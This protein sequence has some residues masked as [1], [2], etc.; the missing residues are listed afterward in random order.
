[1]ADILAALDTI[2]NASDASLQK[3]RDKLGQLLARTAFLLGRSEELGYKPGSDPICTPSQDSTLIPQVRLLAARDDQDARRL[4]VIDSMDELGYTDSD[5]TC[6]PPQNSIL[7]PRVRLLAAP[8]DQEARRLPG[9]EE[10]R[11]QHVTEL[12]DAIKTKL[13][14]IQK[15]YENGSSKFSYPV[16]MVEDSRVLDFTTCDGTKGKRSINMRI[17]RTLS[18]LSLTNDFVAWECLT[19]E[20]SK[21]TCHIN[22]LSEKTEWTG[23]INKFLNERR[24]IDK[25]SA[26]KMIS[27]GTK[28][29]V[30]QALS[31]IPGIAALLSTCPR[32]HEIPYTMLPTLIEG[33]LDRKMYDDAEAY[34]DWWES[35]QENYNNGSRQRKLIRKCHPSQYRTK[36]RRIERNESNI[37][38]RA[39]GHG[40]QN[41]IPEP[42]GSV[43]SEF[44]HTLSS[45]TDCPRS[46]DSTEMRTYITSQAKS[47]ESQI[48]TTASPPNAIRENLAVSQTWEPLEVDNTLMPAN[49]E[50]QPLPVPQF[51]I[52]DTGLHSQHIEEEQPQQSLSVPQ[53]QIIDTGLHSQRIE[54][55]YSFPSPQQQ[56]PQQSLSVPQFQIIDTGLHSQRIEDSY[57][58]AQPQQQLAPPPP[59]P[60]SISTGLQ[61]QEIDG[62]MTS[63]MDFNETQRQTIDTSLQSR[64]QEYQMPLQNDINCFQQPLQTS[65]SFLR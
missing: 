64:Q 30:I 42:N 21:V 54:D 63:I 28:S 8:D 35:C 57:I 12:L 18:I 43:P 13:P 16:S 37:R 61:S 31:G 34:S 33:L 14:E 38:N 23:N 29:I 5:P 53:F 10:K 7:I 51:Q 65:A 4:P 45:A 11:I 60:Q 58:F 36:R 26:R 44:G 59:L 2:C 22:V 1:M 19:F 55:S 49:S 32:W 39:E 41:Y 56:Q 48:F 27:E 46:A 47:T 6:A 52:I 40:D 62:P 3:H 15:A 17:Q 9:K 50:Q 20:Q 25:G 24:I